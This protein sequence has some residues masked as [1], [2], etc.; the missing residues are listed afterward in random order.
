MT[1]RLPIYG[2]VPMIP[3]EALLAGLATEL[4]PFATPGN[5]YRFWTVEKGCWHGPYR[6]DDLAGPRLDMH[7][8]GLEHNAVWARSEAQWLVRP[9]AS[10]PPAGDPS[11][12]CLRDLRAVDDR[13]FAGISFGPRCG[14]VLVSRSTWRGAR[15]E[16]P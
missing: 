1:S 9:I 8:D 15:G 10:A 12:R 2:A 7:A 16:V 13:A 4:Q 3:C 11:R 14:E 5:L 6:L